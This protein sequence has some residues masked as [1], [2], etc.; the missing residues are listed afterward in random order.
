[1]TASAT[2]LLP[3]GALQPAN[4]G[5]AEPSAHATAVARMTLFIGRLYAC[6]A[7]AVHSARGA[8]THTPGRMLARPPPDRDAASMPSMSTTPSPQ[9]KPRGIAARAG[10]WSATHR[11]TA[12]FGWLGFVLVALVVGMSAGAK[13]PSSASK[14]DGESRKAEQV[15][16]DAG[17]KTPD[18]EM[19][20]VQSRTSTAADPAFKDAVADVKRTV[21]RQAAV[22]RI[23]GTQVSKDRHSALVQFD[24]KGDQTKAVDE[25]APVVAAVKSAATRHD[26]VSIRQFGGASA[27]KAVTDSL[28]KDFAK[29]ETLSLPLTLIILLVAFGAL[30]AAGVPLLLGLTAVMGTMGVV[31]GLSHVIEMDDESSLILLVGLAVGVDYSLFYLRREREERA[32]GADKASALQTAAATSGKAVLVSSMTVIIAMAGMFMT[33]NMTFN[34]MAVGTIVVVALAVIGSLTVLP[35]TLAALGDKVEKG[36]IPFLG[37]RRK[38]ARESRIWGAIIDRVMRR[39]KLAIVLAGGLLVA[40]SIPALSM[41]TKQSGIDALPKDIPVVQ[42]YKDVQ[43]AFPSK[44]DTQTV[45]VKADDVTAP[46]VQHAIGELRA[47]A[48]HDPQIVGGITQEIN[49]AHTVTRLTVALPGEPSGDASQSALKHLRNDLLPSTLRQVDGVSANVTGGAASTADFNS[50][51]KSKTPLVFLFVLGLAFILLMA[52]FRSIVIPIKAILLNLLSVGAAY[53]T[54]TAVFQKGWGEKLLG[55]DSNGGVANW[56]PLFLF[57][58]LFGLSMDYHVFIL[59]RVR[60]LVQRGMST[61][62]AVAAGIKSTAGTVTAAAVVM[63]AVFAVF[64]TLGMLDMKEM[65]VG[66]AVA[67]LIDATIVRGVLLPASMKLLGKWNWYLPKRLHWLPEVR[68]GQPEAVPAPA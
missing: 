30:V 9:Q 59:S 68:H 26:G 55:F 14:Y 16:A 37:R 2:T 1:M 34:S 60:E 24:M 36:R 49:P 52:T 17:Y 25:I 38:P 45:V 39:P 62:E 33:G 19:V 42:T 35:A 21:S 46:P 8:A 15:L 27:D 31:T 61:D 54:V 13:D 63:V 22:S 51:M 28:S 44:A 53:G 66:L 12:I 3:T 4:A 58:I 20:L 18:G 64:A 10:H 11:K 48:A 67:I 29:A 7:V 47:K 65:G 56:L 40:M 41:H 32:K 6:R 5:A 43:K 57:V 23:T 50:L